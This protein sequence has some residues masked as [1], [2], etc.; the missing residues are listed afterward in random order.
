MRFVGT[1]LVAIVALVGGAGLAPAAEEAPSYTRDVKPFLAKY[2]MECHSGN[3][4]KAGYSVETFDRLTKMGRKGALVVPEK[5]DDSLVI[6]TMAGKGKQMPPR[7]S[8]QPKAEDIARVRDWIKAGAKD[9]TP[10]D[11]K[12]KPGDI[13]P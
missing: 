13:K 6:R 8:T 10:A 3:K 12:K 2:C 9:D 4:V 1:G 5:P 11:D 7:R